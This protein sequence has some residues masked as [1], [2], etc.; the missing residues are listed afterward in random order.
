M[1]SHA[2]PIRL[3]RA[4]ADGIMP[5]DMRNIESGTNAS[6]SVIEFDEHLNPKLVLYSY[7][8]HQKDPQ[9]SAPKNLV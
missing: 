5:K 4:Y 3:M 8:S 9:E 1:F 6:I 2:T 7:D